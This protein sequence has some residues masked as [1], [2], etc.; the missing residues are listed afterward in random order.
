[1]GLIF[2]NYTQLSLCLM[3]GFITVCHSVWPCFLTKPMR[4]LTLV[5]LSTSLLLTCLLIYFLIVLSVYIPNMGGNGLNLPQNILAWIAI[6]VIVCILFSVA[7]VKKTIK[8]NEPF[9]LFAVGSILI[10]LPFGWSDYPRNIFAIPR[11]MGLIGGLFL[12]G[13]FTGASVTCL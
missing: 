13:S 8:W 11:F 9:L 4:K 12:S 5:K 10:I 7:I 1:M 3:W 6:G 2:Q